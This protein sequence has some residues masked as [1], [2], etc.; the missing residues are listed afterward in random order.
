MLQFTII[1]KLGCD[2]EIKPYNGGKF[3]SLSVADTNTWTDE[4]GTRHEQTQ[5]I[6]CSWNNYQE[7]LLPYLVRGRQVFIQGRGTTRCYSS[8]Q[9]RRF[10]SQAVCFIDRIELLQAPEIVPHELFTENGEIINAEKYYFASLEELAKLGFNPEQ[11]FNLKSK[12]G[13]DFN[14]SK[15]GQITP[16]AIQPELSATQ[17]Q[18]EQTNA[19]TDPQTNQENQ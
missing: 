16:A 5:W 4:S 15:I 3:L 8:P 18:E 14:V 6:Q 9:Q 11:P 13:K 12:A 17:Q 19:I 10:V 2:A 1:G 7:N